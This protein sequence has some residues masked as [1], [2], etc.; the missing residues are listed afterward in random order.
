MGT[1]C[2]IGAIVVTYLE[3]RGWIELWPPA[4]FFRSQQ[5]MRELAEERDRIMADALAR[6]EAQ[7]HK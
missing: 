3:K 6:K 4:K 7:A 1:V 5:R 2:G